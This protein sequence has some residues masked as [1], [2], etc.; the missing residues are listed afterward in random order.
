[1]LEAQ[2]VQKI[3]ADEAEKSDRTERDE[4]VV[5]WVMSSDSRVGF[6]DLDALMS[7]VTLA[8]L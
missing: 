4:S 5:D 1:M 7:L 8:H 3:I 2:T 6:W